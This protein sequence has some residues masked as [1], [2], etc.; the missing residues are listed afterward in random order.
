MWAT[1]Y[2]AQPY[3]HPTIGWRTDIERVPIEK[4]RQFY[5]TFYW[6][7]NATVTLVGDVE[8]ARA[9]ELVKRYYG[10]IPHS[11]H[12]IPEVYTEEPPQ[13]GA[14]RV[15]LKRA[16]ALGSVEIAWKGPNGRD[17]DAPALDVLGAILSAGENSRL[18]LAL[19]D[20]SLVTRAN[21]EIDLLYD[22]GLFEARAGLTPGTSHEE[23][24]KI[25]LTE[26]EKLKR[27]GVTS[28]EVF[29]AVSQLRAQEAYER[30]G[31]TD[32]AAALNEW[33]AAG[34]WTQYVLYIDRVAKVT[35]AD[36]Q[37]V[38]KAYLNEDRSTTGWFVPV[39][40]K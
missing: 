11:P 30:D 23:V 13:T 18:S 21:A 15:L 26:I 8:P 40:A 20:K 28:E 7:D 27:E 24:E 33:I 3:H 37:R 25:I 19:V 31:T 22:P 32:I 1:A 34:D 4:L 12:A 6:P 29:R 39:V 36:V 17:V 14:R 35:P 2:Q 16:G 9:L 10:A 38:A 5:D